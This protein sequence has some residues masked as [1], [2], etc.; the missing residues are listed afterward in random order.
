[1]RTALL[2]LLVFAI[3]Y[4]LTQAAPAAKKKAKKTSKK[5]KTAPVVSAA[6]RAKAKQ[7][8]LN[9]VTASAAHLENPTALTPFFAR[10]QR[11]KDEPVHLLQFGDS[12]T[13]SDDWVN[14]LRERYQ[15]RYGDGG[16]GFVHAGRPFKGYR[17]YDAH[18]N[19]TPSWTTQGTVTKRFDGIDGLSG[20]SISS[21]APA[22]TVSLQAS[23]AALALHYLQ[24]P[25]GGEVDLLIDGQIVSPVKTDGALSHGFYR[26]APPVPG[27]HLYELR[28]A[29][30]LP[31]RLYGWAVDN[32]IGVTV[33]TLGINGAQISMVNEWNEEV[34]SAAVR[35]RDPAL[36]ILAYGTNE[37]VN[38]KFS[39]EQY[40]QDLTAAIQKV[41]RAAPMASILLLGPPDASRAG[42][43]LRY[44]ADVIEVQRQVA[45][46][47]SVAYWNL[48]KW[49]GG[50]GST[51]LWVR[52]GLGQQDHV[53]LTVEGY[54][55]VGKML[56]EDLE[57]AKMEAGG[58]EGQQK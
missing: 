37:A 41:R 38:P 25:G 34:W 47:E 8:I 17:R 48:R 16:P 18:G 53:H 3:P 15:A 46:Q 7:D 23:G 6:A 14:A 55:L 51:N 43:P 56:F 26:V 30:G 24:Q 35:Q 42:R 33:E 11:S 19:A 31:V 5:K 58:D 12:H 40:R 10:L 36:V 4:S 45:K 2:V 13:A 54:R 21:S 32:P 1:M 27:D 20:L 28:K 57:A 50:T 9:S 22:A 44:L 39:P 49:M 29:D 52:A